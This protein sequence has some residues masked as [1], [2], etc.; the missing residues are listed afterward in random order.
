MS[1]NPPWEPNDPMRPALVDPDNP[2][3][4]ELAAM[5]PEQRRRYEP[6]PGG[7]AGGKVRRCIWPGCDWETPIDAAG[8]AS[9]WDVAMKR[10]VLTHVDE[11]HP[12]WMDELAAIVSLR[13]AE[14][15]VRALAALG[16]L[17]G[18]EILFNGHCNLCRGDCFA[19]MLAQ[20]EEPKTVEA[21]ESLDWH[22]PHCPW[23]LARE[24]VTANGDSE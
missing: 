20:D 18:P 4:A 2:T 14:A 7:P 9:G 22:E 15:I 13:Q 23:R 3:P 21:A 11:A 10:T 19:W 24:W 12:D 17:D 8:D 6:A 16:P 1:A 5:S